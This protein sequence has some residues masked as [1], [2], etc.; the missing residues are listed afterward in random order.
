MRSNQLAE[1]VFTSIP[2]MVG[3]GRGHIGADGA[4]KLGLGLASGHPS[5]Y[6]GVATPTFE[7]S[8][9]WRKRGSERRR[10]PASL[11]MK[12]QHGKGA[13]AGMIVSVAAMSGAR[14][15]AKLVE[16]TRAATR[17]HRSPDE[18]ANTAR[19]KWVMPNGVA[20]VR[21]PR[22]NATV[23]LSILCSIMI[24]QMHADVFIDVQG[25][26]S[27]RRTHC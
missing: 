9:H 25:R 5:M 18:G 14:T 12:Q 17:A 6:T 20:Q 4:A 3:R 1:D 21:P 16:G 19:I 11:G 13:K 10:Q 24:K 8:H 22:H 26:R 15:T 2:A 27:G 23:P 7:C